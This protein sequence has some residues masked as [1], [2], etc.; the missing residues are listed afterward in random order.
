MANTTPLNESQQEAILLGNLVHL[1]MAEIKTTNDVK[2][3][4]Q[5][6]NNQE[7][8][9]THLITEKVNAIVNHPE[10]KDYFTSNNKVLTEVELLSSDGVS[11]RPDR[12]NISGNEATIID[13]KTGLPNQKNNS[14]VMAYADLLSAMN[15]KI[16]KKII[17]Y[18]N[19]EISLE[20]L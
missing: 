18:I 6:L 12:I 17:V 15:F 14:Q 1:V 20:Y 7:E 19:Q 10:L 3:A 8:Q 11:Q 13:Y 4:L 2:T 9:L 5:Q 16:D